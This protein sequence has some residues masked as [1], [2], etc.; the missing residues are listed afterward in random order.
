MI[1]DI[2]DTYSNKYDNTIKIKCIYVKSNSYPE[3]N[4]DSN[5]RTPKYK[6][7]FAKGYAPSWSKEVL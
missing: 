1:Y 7:M 4:V 2:L 6:N 5:A 3:F